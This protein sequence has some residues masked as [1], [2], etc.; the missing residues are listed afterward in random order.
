MKTQHI[1]SHSDYPK[2]IYPF[3]FKIESNNFWFQSRNNIIGAYLKNLFPDEIEKNLL[4]I[5]CG[6]GFVL[7]YLEKMGFIVTGLDLNKVGLKFAYKRLKKPNLI[8]SDVY[9]YDTKKQY[10]IVCLFDV[11]EHFDDDSSIIR[12]CKNLIKNNGY[13]IITIPA[14]K[15]LWSKIDTLSGHKRRYSK[16]KLIKLLSTAGYT[17]ERVNY[18]HFSLYLPRVIFR[19]F[20]EI[21]YKN[22]INSNGLLEKSLMI[23]KYFNFALKILLSFENLLFDFIPFPVGTSLII[24]AR[25]S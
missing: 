16:E 3:L 23:N 21:K 6:T 1:K 2:E 19:K 13:L 4:E 7:S 9:K 25:K 20:I 12:K 17:I 8:C 10:D 24:R 15:E 5:G 11:I 18:F 22:Q 14:R